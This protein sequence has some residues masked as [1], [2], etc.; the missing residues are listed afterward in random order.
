LIHEFPRTADAITTSWL[1][2]VFDAPVTGF[3]TTFLEGGVLSDAFKLHD[4]TYDGPCP[5]APRSA[6]VKLAQAEQGRRE[7]ALAGNAY[8]KELNFFRYLAPEIPVRTPHTYAVHT[9]GSAGSEYF[10][11]VMEDL[12]THSK[13]FDQV[14]DQP[15]AAFTR[16]IALEAAKMHAKYWESPLLDEPWISDDPGRYLFPMDPLCRQSPANLDTYRTLWEQKF[17]VDPLRALG[18]EVEQL[19]L[20]LTGPKCDAIHDRMY[21]ILSSRPRTL[22]H[23]DMRADNV[24]RTRPELGRSVE[25]SEVTFID[26]QL[27]TAGP[28]GPEFTQSWQHSLTTE[29]RRNDRQILKEYHEALVSLNPAAAAYTYDNLLE[30]YKLGFCFWWTALITLGISV[31]PAFDT[32]AGARMKAL[33]GQGLPNALQAMIDHDCLTTIRGIADKIPDGH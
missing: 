22:I 33:W 32:P 31:V 2:E 8:L 6:V 26:W 21:E 18:D 25:Q 1:S 14:N 5:D 15:D 3:Q 11:I 24:F 23:G 10:I 4:I 30:D 13:V 28:P 20:L 12:T 9:D 16:K 27:L 19:T 7:S 29:V 17:G